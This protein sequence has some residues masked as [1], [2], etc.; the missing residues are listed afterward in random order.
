[1]NFIAQVEEHL[2][3]LGTEARKKHPGV[4]EASERAILTLRSLQS[5]YISAVRAATASN[6]TSGSTPKKHPTTSLFRS[7]DVLRPFLLACNYPDASSELI[8]VGI[9]AMQLLIRG[10]AVCPEDSVHIARVLGI[11]AACCCRHNGNEINSQRAQG[12]VMASLMGAAAPGGSYSSSS[13]LSGSGNRGAKENET[14][15]LKLLQTLTMIFTSK[16][17]ILGEEVLGQAITVCLTII[18]GNEGTR[19]DRQRRR[20][21][22]SV[23]DSTANSAGHPASIGGNV[24]I[25][26]AAA[27]TLKQILILTF[28]R[29]TS[30]DGDSEEQLKATKHAA[31]RAF[32]DLCSLAENRSDDETKIA[33]GPFSIHGGAGVKRNSVQPPPQSACFELVDMILHQK[34]SFFLGEVSEEQK[35]KVVNNEDADLSDCFPALLRYRTC[36]LVSTFLLGECA[37]ES[38]RDKTSRKTNEKKNLSNKDFSL[39]TRSTRL[40]STVVLKFGRTKEFSGECHII[41][42]ALIRFV[43]SSSEAY[44]NT[45]HF[46]DGYIY[47]STSFSQ[48]LDSSQSSGLI[49]NHLLWRSALALESLY[50]ITANPLMLKSLKTSLDIQRPNA[51]L[52]AVIAEAVSSFATIAASNKSSILSV[53]SVVSERKDQNWDNSVKGNDKT[54]ILQP[55]IFARARNI[56]KFYD[57]WESSPTENNFNTFNAENNPSVD[58]LLSDKNSSIPY[59]NEGEAI[60][61]AFNCTLSLASSLRELSTEDSGEIHSLVEIA[62]AP[63]LSV[64]QHFLKRFPAQNEIR[65]K[66]LDG[67]RDLAAASIPLSSVHNEVQIEALFKS[68][69]KLALPGQGQSHSSSFQDQHAAIVQLLL[70]LTHCYHDHIFSVWQIILSTLEKLSILPVASPALSKIGHNIASN[71]S[72]VFNRLSSFTTCFTDKSLQFFIGA[73]LELSKHAIFPTANSPFSK[74]K[75][76]NNSDNEESN[77]GSTNTV[78]LSGKLISFAGRAFINSYN[79]SSDSLENDSFSQQNYSSKTFAEDFLNSIFNRLAITKPT[80]KKEAFQTLPF[81]LIALTDVTLSNSFRFTSFA[82]PVTN[83]LCELAATSQNIDVRAYSMD[84]LASLITTRLAENGAHYT[85]KK[86]CSVPLQ[87]TS[88]TNYFAVEQ[89]EKAK[90]S[91]DGR[92]SKDDMDMSQAELLRPL[93]NTITETPAKDAAEAGLNALHVILESSGHNLSGDAWPVIISAIS[94]LSGVEQNRNSQSW[95]ACAS[96]SFRCLRL[97][98][99]D[100]LDQLPV[101]PSPHAAPTRNSLLHCCASF[102]QSQFDINTSLTA[103]GMLWTIADTNPSPNALEDVSSK[104]AFLV[105]DERAEVRST[106]MENFMRSII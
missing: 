74:R 18:S 7:Q 22:R 85:M 86:I 72:D 88:D 1:M 81:S 20:F 23:S 44:R 92:D 42:T 84:T 105:C 61:I 17:L 99:N 14:I 2:R 78:S 35:H 104:L 95:S 6:T 68:L 102:G 55:Q 33:V 60:W 103:I 54:S 97:I 64:L 43:S 82:D 26:R 16:G 27:A 71:I 37:L 77:S 67:Y 21:Q 8:L 38:K 40:A 46:E 52:I 96:L 56:T 19:D 47:S 10:D 49:P 34:T 11:Q 12:G 30:D 13:G 62:F 101:P 32:S 51:T 41:L 89:S 53:V 80:T 28:D 39:L 45:D 58:R 93:C 73:L 59:C 91:E 31:A 70:E 69:C 83:Y 66:A 5:R 65:A 76:T 87:D 98:V 36:P 25:R 9:S 29:A 94:S 63:S 57:D 48:Q 3:D 90:D 4:K 75:A 100:F 50:C 106:L 15:S 79:A 24:N